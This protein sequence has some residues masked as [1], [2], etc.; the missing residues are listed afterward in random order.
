MSQFFKNFEED[1]ISN[2]PKKAPVKPVQESDEEE[3]EKIS[4]KEKRLNELQ[5]EVFRIEE[6]CDSREVEAFLKNIK[7]YKTVIKDGLPLFLV[8]F[9]KLALESQ[10]MPQ[11]TKNKIKKF[12]STNA[13]QKVEPV[14]VQA[15]NIV[16]DDQND[17]EKEEISLNNT[18]LDLSKRLAYEELVHEFENLRDLKTKANE[19]A[20]ICLSLLNLHMKNKCGDFNKVASLL[21]E[22]LDCVKDEV[23]FM[24]INFKRYF[25][26]N[27][28]VYLDYLISISRAINHDALKGYFKK[29]KYLN[30]ELVERKELEFK[31]YVLN[32][33]VET[34]D[35]IYHLLYLIRRKT[36][37]NAY[38]YYT[39]NKGTYRNCLKIKV[40]LGLL[41][42]ES[43]DFLVAF[44]IL[45]QCYLEG[46]RDNENILFILCIILENEVVDMEFFDIFID[47]IRIIED[48]VFM[49]KTN[50]IKSEIFRAYY[51]LKNEDYVNA[52]K[53][54]SE[55]APGVNFSQI[56]KSV[57]ST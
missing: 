52:D 33:N 1:N 45:Q 22:I 30:N 38:N 24:E 48:N 20:K 16:V 55:I 17:E 54:L 43:C 28:D 31:F 10:K 42:F 56:F 6:T 13:A 9:L 40:E 41:A 21:D 26:K 29:T 11:G 25:Q 2:Q 32:E 35:K 27:I 57:C 47:N 49:L 4:N 37:Q 50:T 39:A 19:R 46:F 8:S 7:K 3:E 36:Y 34:D 23:Q 12:L 18:I 14:A 15:N 44:N 51:L 53:I 5:E